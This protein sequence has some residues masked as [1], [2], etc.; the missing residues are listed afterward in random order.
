MTKYHTY[1]Y[2]SNFSISAV[3]YK[4][5]SPLLFSTFDTNPVYILP[6]QNQLFLTSHLN[7]IYLL[8]S[9]RDVQYDVLP[10]DSFRLLFVLLYHIPHAK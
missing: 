5:V 3:P 8:A 10:A 1:L 6:I 7:I 9:N 4:T 2:T